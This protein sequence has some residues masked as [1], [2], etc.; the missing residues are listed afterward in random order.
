MKVSAKNGTNIEK[1]FE[2]MINLFEN[3]NEKGN[4]ENEKEKVLKLNNS[5][6]KKSGCC[7]KKKK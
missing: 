1:A 2:E 7:S 3:D 6:K 5:T 4:I